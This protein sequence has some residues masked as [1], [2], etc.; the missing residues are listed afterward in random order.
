[1]QINI[2]GVG[3]S[4]CSKP[5]VSWC[6]LGRSKW[7]FNLVYRNPHSFFLEKTFQ[8]EAIRKQ[9]IAQTQQTFYSFALIK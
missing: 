7:C 6:F 8:P 2:L 9:T 1:M 4:E 3:P 5:N